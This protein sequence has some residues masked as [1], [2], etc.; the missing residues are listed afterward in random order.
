MIKILRAFFLS[1]LAIGLVVSLFAYSA[2]K[3]PVNAYL[4]QGSACDVEN[5]DDYPPCSSQCSNTLA[6]DLGWCNEIGGIC[7][8]IVDPNNL[9]NLCDCSCENPNKNVEC[10]YSSDCNLA[11]GETCVQGTC[12]AP[13]SEACN[14]QLGGSD[15]WLPDGPCDPNN[16]DHDQAF[17]VDDDLDNVGECVCTADAFFGDA[18]ALCADQESIDTAIGCIPVKSDQKFAEFVLSWAMGIGGGVAF[19]LGIVAGFI[20]MTS[21]GDPQRLNSGKA[22]LMAALSGLFLLLGSAFILRIVGVE[23]FGIPGL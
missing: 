3:K 8:D 15:C 9:V 17:C 12:E 1:F 11:D 5:P 18:Q 21:S 7:T 16:P 6:A 14:P 10:V 4:L 19:L 20:I 13:G 2:D 22:L 23:L